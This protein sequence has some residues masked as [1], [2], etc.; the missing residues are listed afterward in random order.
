M[1]LNEYFEFPKPI[2]L[3]KRCLRLACEDDDIVLDFFA[4]SSTSAQATLE[5]NIEDAENRKFIAVQFPEPTN[6]ERF[7]TIAEI[8]KERIRRVIQK[9]RKENPMFAGQGQ[10][11]G[12]R[13]LKLKHSNFKLWRSDGIENAEDL[14]EQLDFLKDPVREDTLEENI[15]TELLLKSG[16]PLTAHMEKQEVGASHYY[17]VSSELAV[18][19]GE[20]DE[21]L[22]R[23]VIQQGVKQFICLDRSF[24]NNDQLK[25]NTQLQLK[26]AGIAFHSI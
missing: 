7:G 1:G 13:V 23:D 4:G 21:D 20:L 24:A 16:Y 18:A 9:I 14:V 25:T 19:P 15:L 10:D 17:L 26:D 8:S 11:L 12:F 6:H 2:Q 22:I 3:I 5:L